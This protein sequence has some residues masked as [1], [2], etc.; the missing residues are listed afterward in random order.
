VKIAKGPVWLKVA[1]RA[2]HA[3]LAV[4]ELIATAATEGFT[5]RRINP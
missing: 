1:F 2:C 3:V 5:W 4:V